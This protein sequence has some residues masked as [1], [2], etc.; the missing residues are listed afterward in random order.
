[1][2]RKA[3]LADNLYQ[4]TEAYP[5]HLSVGAV[6]R[7]ADGKILCHR[8]DDVDLNP[9]RPHPV[10]ILMRET[11][12][13]TESL[14]AAVHRGIREEFG[15]TAQITKF[16]GSIISKAPAK[17]G[18]FEKT[19]AYFLCELK[20]VDL[21]LRAGDPEAVS[22]PVYMDIGEL[23][24]AMQAQAALMPDRTDVDESIILGRI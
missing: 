9:I 4:N 1:M 20:T 14:E 16:L 11:V 13:T 17:Y 22:E 15:A 3:M 6:M 12:E 7:G 8:F 10:Y 2:Y 5:Y 23:S 19:T 24:A 18:S 21:A